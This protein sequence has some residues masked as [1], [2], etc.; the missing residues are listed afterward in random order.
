MMQSWYGKAAL[1]V[2][3]KGFRCWC[4]G[5]SVAAPRHDEGLIVEPETPVLLQYLLRRLEVRAALHD[6][7]EPL[8]LDLIDVDRRVPGGEQRR[9]ADAVADLRGERVHLVAEDRLVVG[10]RD[11]REIACIA[12]ELRLEGREQ[13]MPVDLERVLS[14]P[15][16]LNDLE[17]GIASAGLNREQA[18]AGSQAANERREDLL[19]LELRHHAR[20]PRL[21]GDDQI[22]ALE[23]AP[24]L[25]NHRVEQEFVVFAVDDEHRRPEEHGIARLRA[26]ARLP[27]VI[28]R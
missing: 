27:A 3:K 20:A 23:D 9:G 17:G 11:E 14:R 19:G 28:E 21:G 8:V 6:R 2:E 24:R 18:P 4:G 1:A 22:V 5:H 25:R 15:E 10:W 13:L 16:S 7:I 26:R 12:T